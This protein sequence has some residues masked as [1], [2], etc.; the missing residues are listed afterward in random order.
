MKEFVKAQYILP[1][2]KVDIVENDII[3]FSEG[4]GS[5]NVWDGPM[6]GGDE[7]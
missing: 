2:I 3:T 4:T 1:E 5:D 7:E 6:I